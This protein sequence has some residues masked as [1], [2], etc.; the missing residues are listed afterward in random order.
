MN[1]KEKVFQQA[2][3]LLSQILNVRED[4]I[5][6]EMRLYGDP[7]VH[8]LDMARLVMACERFFDI[9]IHDEDVHTF[10]CFDDCVRYIAE[11]LSEGRQSVSLS[12]DKE[13]EAWYYE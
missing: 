1:D 10:V 12:S 2:A 9:V 7:G 5:G 8:P 3:V 6:P 13:R 11:A 4:E